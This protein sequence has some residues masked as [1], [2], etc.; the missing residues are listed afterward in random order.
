MWFRKYVKMNRQL[1]YDGINNTPESNPP[2]LIFWYDHY[3]RGDSV[4]AATNALQYS[5]YVVTHWRDSY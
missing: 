3:N 1:R 4:A 2:I 5:S